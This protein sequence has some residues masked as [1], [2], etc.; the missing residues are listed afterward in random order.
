MW[1]FNKFRDSLDRT[2]KYVI[3]AFISNPNKRYR[4]DDNEINPI[5][6]K[7]FVDKYAIIRFTVNGGT[8]LLKLIDVDS[9]FKKV[10][11]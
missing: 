8:R 10:S 7:R 4:L 6:A 1:N 2:N 9:N 3:P 5:F 11:K